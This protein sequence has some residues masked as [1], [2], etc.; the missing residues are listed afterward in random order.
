VPP[1]N[2]AIEHSN[3]SLLPVESAM[4]GMWP[5]VCVRGRRHRQLAPLA[6]SPVNEQAVCGLFVKAVIGAVEHDAQADVAP[7]VIW[8]CHLP[9]WMTIGMLVVPNT[10]SVK[11]P[12]M[13]VVVAD[14]D[15]DRRLEHE[16]HETPEEG[17][18]TAPEGW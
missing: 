3:G 17:A 10:S 4:N 16:S 11:L 14:R 18:V 1:M 8:R 15:G 13:S 7:I 2:S 9:V 6:G 5:S 12:L